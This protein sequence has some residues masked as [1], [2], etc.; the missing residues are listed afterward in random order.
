MLE[1]EK[2]LRINRNQM[3]FG[4]MKKPTQNRLTVI[5]HFR[6][7]VHGTISSLATF[8]LFA[9]SFAVSL[10]CVS[11]LALTLVLSLNT[12]PQSPL[13][14]QVSLHPIEFLRHPQKP[15]LQPVLHPHV[16]FWERERLVV[17]RELFDFWSSCE[18]FEVFEIVR[19]VT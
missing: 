9:A 1:I 13:Q 17:F 5:Y 3:K 18:S 8:S 19:M 10:A 12:L 14:W 7:G 11:L 2:N 6:F 16:P 4:R 15:A